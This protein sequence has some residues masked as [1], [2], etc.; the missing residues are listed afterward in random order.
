MA[1]K[2]QRGLS[3]GRS[4]LRHSATPLDLC[5]DTVGPVLDALADPE[6]EIPDFRPVAVGEGDRRPS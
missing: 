5:T 4:F 2:R 1:G 6:L 3:Q